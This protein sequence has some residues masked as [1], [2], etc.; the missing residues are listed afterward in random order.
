MNN[1]PLTDAIRLKHTQI[2]AF[3]KDKGGQLPQMIEE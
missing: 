3:L 1:T 2:A